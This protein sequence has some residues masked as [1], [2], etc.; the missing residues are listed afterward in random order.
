[1]NPLII[2]QKEKGQ[3][4]DQTIKSFTLLT[5]LIWLVIPVYLSSLPIAHLSNTPRRL[6]VITRDSAGIQ[7]ETTESFFWF[8]D[9]LGVW[10]A[11]DSNP[12]PV[13]T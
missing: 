11:G 8:S 7:D 10:P 13:V 9:V 6:L 3:A 12:Q 4:R 2:P 5:E 1:M